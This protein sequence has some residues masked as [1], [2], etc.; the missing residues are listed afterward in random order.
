MEV[1]EHLNTCKF[2]PMK[3]FLQHSADQIEVLQTEL[4]NKDQV[5]RISVTKIFYLYPISFY[6]CMIFLL[7]FAL[8]VFILNFF[9]LAHCYFSVFC[10]QEITFLRSMLFKMSERIERVEK[11]VDIRLG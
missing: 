5:L 9:I 4:K 3:E 11:T 6:V 8:I 10:Y 2:E 7:H 1:E